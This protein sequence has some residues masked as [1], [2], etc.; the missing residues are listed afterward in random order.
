MS[1]S[2][3]Y[4]IQVTQLKTN[5]KTPVLNKCSLKCLS[6]KVQQQQQNNKQINKKNHQQQY[7]WDTCCK[8]QVFLAAALQHA[9]VCPNPAGSSLRNPLNVSHWINTKQE[10]SASPE[11]IQ[12]HRCSRSIPSLQSHTLSYTCAVLHTFQSS[13]WPTPP[14]EG[15][16]ALYPLGTWESWS[17]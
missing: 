3:C 7:C 4:L 2:T 11:C 5:K 16:E 17:P 12:I 10:K 6:H 14:Q 13:L 8:I 9:S 15:V 1:K